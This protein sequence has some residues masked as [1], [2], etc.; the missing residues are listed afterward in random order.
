MVG[1]G[2]TTSYGIGYRGRVTISD[3]RVPGGSTDLPGTAADWR[4]Q[5][6][7][8]SFVEVSAGGPGALR[9]ELGSDGKATPVLASRWFPAAVPAVIVDPGTPTSAGIL[10]SGLTGK[11]RPLAT[12]AELPWAPGLPG[13]AAVVDLD[14]LRHWGSRVGESGRIQVWFDTEDPAALARVRDALRGQGIEVSGVRRLSEVRASYDASVPAW[15]LQLGV[16]AAVAGL[17]LAALVLVLLVASTW[18]RRSRDLA[19]L[20]MGGVPR[21]GL[22]R[23]AV[24]ELLPTVVLAVLAGGGCGLLGAILALPTVPLFAQPRPA[25]T[26]DLSVPWAPVLLA[27]A[28]ALVVLG[29]V[30]W[31]SGRA[32]AAAGARLSRVREVL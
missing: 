21:R 32:V 24:G 22:G 18:R 29:L 5:G 27:L 6:A 9:M 11:D 12:V 20:G 23:I 3:V 26:L 2:V 17:L 1:L 14:L 8:L 19:C 16:L 7:K 15:S 28:A 25:S 10:G 13:A 30:A 31:L 4:P